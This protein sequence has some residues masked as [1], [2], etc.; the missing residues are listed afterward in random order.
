MAKAKPRTE[1]DKALERMVAFGTE[2]FT[3][4]KAAVEKLERARPKR[5]KKRKNKV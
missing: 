2:L 4:P 5:A 3:V 1:A